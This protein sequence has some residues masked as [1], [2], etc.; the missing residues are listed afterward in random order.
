MPDTIIT[1]TWS[2]FLK[3]WTIIAINVRGIANFNPNSSGTIE[4]SRIPTIV[5]ICQLNH[6]VIPEPIKW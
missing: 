2:I 1:K 6:K 5:D 3:S 4:P